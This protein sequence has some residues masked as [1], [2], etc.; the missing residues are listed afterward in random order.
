MKKNLFLILMSITL[1]W[2]CS[3]GEKGTG[4]G[5]KI[6]EPKPVVTVSI[7]PQRYFVQRIVGDNY[8]VKVMIPPGHSPAT[9][10]PTP[11]EMKTVSE[12]VLYFRIGHIAFEK[13]W[14]DNIASLN[15]EMTVVDTSR[16]VS[17]ITGAVPHSHGESEDGRHH[18]HT[19][20]DPHIWLS[21]SAVKIQI[22]H[23]LDAFMDVET[24]PENRVLYETNYRNFVADI[25]TLEAKNEAILSPLKGNKFMVYHPAWSYFAREYGLIQFP[26]EMEGK[27]PGAADMKR[28]IDTANRENIRVIFVQQ[29]FD[30][31]SARAVANEIT[32]KVIAMDPLAPD[33]LENMKK[34]ALTFKKALIEE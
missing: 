3:Q 13:A 4:T 30:S 1:L 8:R 2:N 21:P 16:D 10:E 20:I 22:K 32:G 9:Y 11:R 12:S 19:G 7:L 24:N 26:I 23:I 25:E 15:K 6:Q 14:M 28:I 18:D 29:Q 33:W 5:E 17:L 27:I 31:N 34:I